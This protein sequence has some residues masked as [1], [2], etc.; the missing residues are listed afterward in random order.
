M[1]RHATRLHIL[2][3]R[4]D[5]GCTISMRD[6]SHMWKTIVCLPML[7][8]TGLVLSAAC[9]GPRDVSAGETATSMECAQEEFGACD[10]RPW[11]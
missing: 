8:R 11:R 2:C 4:T 3:A 1:P 5:G 10:A 6:S 9:S 7:S